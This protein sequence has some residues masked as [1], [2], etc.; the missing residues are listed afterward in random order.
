MAAGL[1][2]RCLDRVGR[3]PRW[4]YRGRMVRH[5]VSDQDGIGEEGMTFREEIDNEN[6]YDHHFFLSANV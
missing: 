5:P 4:A 3:Q 6:S 1:A 2:R